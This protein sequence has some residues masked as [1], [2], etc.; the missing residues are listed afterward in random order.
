ML[1]FALM[2]RWPA[3]ESWPRCG[4]TCTVGVSVTK[5]W[6]RR[7]LM[8]RAEMVASSTVEVRTEEVVSTAV[9]PP[10]TVTASWMVPTF[11]DMLI[12]S[13]EPT[14]TLIPVCFAGWKPGSE[15]VTS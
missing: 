9:T 4:S 7:P 10:S 3:S 14:V 12:V 2:P 6:N 13:C 8:G 5:S 1:T 15:P 11:R